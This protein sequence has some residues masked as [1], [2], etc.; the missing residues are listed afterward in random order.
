MQLSL[1]W[2]GPEDNVP[3]KH[4]RQV[5]GVVVVVT[6]LHDIAPGEVWQPEPINL[7]VDQIKANGLALTAVESL[8]VHEDI[9]LGRPDRD[10]YIENYNLSLKNLASSGVT[11]VCYN[12]MPIFDWTRTISIEKPNDDRLN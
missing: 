11:T 2:Y 12:F 3:L 6:L 5:P 10:R 4:T 8:P 1:R 9:K 7:L